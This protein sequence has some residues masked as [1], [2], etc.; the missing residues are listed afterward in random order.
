MAE[1]PSRHTLQRHQLGMDNDCMT[2]L[3]H[4]NFDRVKEKSTTGHCSG[5][6]AQLSVC[7]MLEDFRP[8]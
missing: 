7:F 2:I 6:R 4:A 3:F 1:F 5:G 8:E